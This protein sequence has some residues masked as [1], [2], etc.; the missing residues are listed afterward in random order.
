MFEVLDKHKKESAKEYTKRTLLHNLINLKLFPGQVVSEQEI[1]NL[2][3]VS[4]TPVREAFMELARVSMLKISPQKSTVISLIDP[5][6]VEDVRFIRSTLEVAIVGLACD[7]LT[8]NQLQQLEENCILQQFALENKNSQRL[9]ELDNEYHKL[10]FYFC[11]KETTY[12][13]MK[14][15]MAH[16]DRVRALS[17]VIIDSHKV[18]GDHKKL[19]QAIRAGNKKKAVA[20]MKKHLQLIIHDLP[21]LQKKHPEYFV[22]SEK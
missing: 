3:H 17:L 7:V 11:D 1:A 20:L 14:E 4:R 15:F 8:E 5:V 22:N 6:L 16:F 19:V 18:V 21:Y 10:L 13:F 9:L 2:L 12:N